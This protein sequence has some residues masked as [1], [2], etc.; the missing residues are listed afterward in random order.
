MDHPFRTAVF[1][2]FQREDVLNYLAEQAKQ[3]QRQREELERQLEEHRR[4][5]RDAQRQAE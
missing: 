5:A 4:G 1:G 3:N 2:G